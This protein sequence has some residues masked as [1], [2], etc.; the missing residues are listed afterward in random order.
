LLFCCSLRSLRTPQPD[1]L[2]VSKKAPLSLRQRG[3][4]FAF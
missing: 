4:S 2:E 3:F 1:Q